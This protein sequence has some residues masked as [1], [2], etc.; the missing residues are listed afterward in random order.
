MAAAL[1]NTSPTMVDVAK[2]TDTQGRI[3]PVVESLAQKNALIQSMAFKEGNTDTGHQVASRNSLPSITWIRL[4]EGILPGKSTTDTYV[5][6]CGT[7]ESM[8]SIDTR[9]ADLNGNALAFRASEDDAFLASMT[10]NLESA[11]FYETTAANPERILG[12]APRLGSTASKYGAQILKADSSASG[13]NQSSIWFVGWGDR[14]VY[15]ISPRGQGTGLEMIDKGIQRDKDNTTGAIMWKYETLFRWKVGLCVEDYRYVV[16][17]AN[18]DMTRINATFTAGTT[19]LTDIM[20]QAYYQIFD[21]NAVRIVAYCDRKVGA[22]LHRQALNKTA[23]GA[24]TVD[25]APQLGAPGVFGKPIVR[26]LGSP[27]YVTDAIT[28]TEALVA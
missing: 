12:L 20:I 9:V 17:I 22:F 21:P 1:A 14:T 11:F 24:L 25:P 19:D 5:E 16:R 27:I 3:L 18:I 28:N 13:A 2:R 23:S 10:N 15:G 7:M 26:F 6:H 4:N 8:S